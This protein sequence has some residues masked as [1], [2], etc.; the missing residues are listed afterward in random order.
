[1]A[2]EA[3]F[4]RRHHF[5]LVKGYKWQDGAAYTA[6]RHTAQ[7]H[8]ARVGH[9][10]R[11]QKAKTTSTL[12]GADIQPKERDKGGAL[13]LTENAIFKG[14]LLDPFVQLAADLKPNDKNLLHE[15][16]LRRR[17]RVTATDS[18]SRSYF[19]AIFVIRDLISLSIL[20]HST[21]NSQCHCN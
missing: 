1:M 16:K 9:M 8:A 21:H 19:D 17:P 18:G 7:S 5:V 10:R 11:K 6:H 4:L 12:E 14:S 20:S 3:Q 2:A 13:A 15:C